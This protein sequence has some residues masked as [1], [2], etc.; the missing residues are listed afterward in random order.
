MNPRRFSWP[1]AARQLIRHEPS[2]RCR[3][4]NE[5]CVRRGTRFS[6]RATTMLI[7]RL[8]WNAGAGGKSSHPT[9]SGPSPRA[10]LKV[11]GLTVTATP[12]SPPL[13]QSG[14]LRAASGR[15][16][17]QSGLLGQEA[18]GSDPLGAGAMPSGS[19]LT[20][21]ERSRACPWVALPA[22]GDSF[23]SLP[24]SAGF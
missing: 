23:V 17:L 3:C 22:A 11:R 14:T 24:R 21:R 2:P 8:G 5:T 18:A 6:E 16:E 7:V 12:G 13:P 15:R 20:K 19:L 4:E 1:G 10:H 9:V